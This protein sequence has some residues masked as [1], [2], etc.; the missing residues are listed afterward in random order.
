VAAGKTNRGIAARAVHQRED[1]RAA[2]QQ[3]LHE[4]AAFLPG[5]GD[6]VRLQ[7]RPRPVAATTQ[8]CPRPVAANGCLGRGW[9]AA[10][11]LRSRANRVVAHTHGRRKR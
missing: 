11:L 9:T 6:R 3:H 10:R 2:R 8:N 5:R 1:G 7:A 4:V